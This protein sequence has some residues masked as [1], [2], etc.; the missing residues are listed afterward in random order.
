MPIAA[1]T[2]HWYC[3]CDL[4]LQWRIAETHFGFLF[5]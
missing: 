4:E 1:I 3:R 5:I 2:Y